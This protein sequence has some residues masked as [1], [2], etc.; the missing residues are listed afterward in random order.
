LTVM[1]IITLVI[2]IYGAALSTFNIW[3]S[4]DKDRVKL[5]VIP[6]TTQS[7]GLGQS[8]IKTSSLTVYVNSQLCI[9]IVNLSSFPVTISEVGLLYRGSKT[10]GTL[11]RPIIHDGGSFPRR[12]EPRSSFTVFFEYGVPKS[13]PLFL[14]AKCAYAKTDCGITVKSKGHFFTKANLNAL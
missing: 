8:M 5:K 10:R 12:L 6:K 11:A 7:M 9:D 13:D 4:L 1:N 3:R 14:N 2:A